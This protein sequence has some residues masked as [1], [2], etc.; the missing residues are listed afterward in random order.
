M[1][2]K[3]VV[4]NVYLQ[5]LIKK[6]GSQQKIGVPVPPNKVPK[7]PVR[8]SN[9]RAKV[10]QVNKQMDRQIFKKGTKIPLPVNPNQEKDF[11]IDNVDNTNVT[12]KNLKP[13]PGEPELTTMK[14]S[15]LNP[16]IN[17]LLRRGRAQTNR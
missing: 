1:K 12:L 3:E 4:E 6:I 16:V 10:N 7:G 2:I 17:N 5:N 8:S 13:K 9:I 15:D 11:E 14:K